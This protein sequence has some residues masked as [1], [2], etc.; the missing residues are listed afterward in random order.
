[1]QLTS[2]PN[3]DGPSAQLKLRLKTEPQ[4]AAVARTFVGS[5]LRAIDRDP[6]VVDDLRLVVSELFTVLVAERYGSIDVTLTISG[7]AVIAVLAGPSDL[8]ALPSETLA[9]TRKLTGEEIQLEDSQWVI[10]ARPR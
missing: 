4:N 1:M 8:P 10:Q 9:L 7:E 2:T 3:S 5:A 6:S